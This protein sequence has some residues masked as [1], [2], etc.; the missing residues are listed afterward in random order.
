MRKPLWCSRI[1][2]LRWIICQFG[3][4]VP[5][6]KPL[7]EGMSSILNIIARER[8]DLVPLLNQK[9]NYYDIA[10]SRV[11]EITIPGAID[12]YYEDY[13][14]AFSWPAATGKDQFTRFFPFYP[15]SVDVL[16]SVSYHLTTIRSALYFM[17]ETLKRQCKQKSTELVTL[18]TLFD[19]VVNYVEDPSGTTR[20][21][22]S[23][24]TKFPNEWRAYDQACQ[25]IN[26][27]TKG[28][29]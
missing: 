8:L 13:K 22:A 16:R 2:L 23:I 28:L 20:S 9:D 29:S 14:R 1:G 18:W 5:H 6:N 11:R 15:P 10:L 27:A 19:D 17:L 3:Q 4:C 26:A 24:R 21:I 12:Q 25:Q 7:N